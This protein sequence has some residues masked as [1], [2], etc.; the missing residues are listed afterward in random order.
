M[1]ILL[2]FD[3][4]S[5]TSDGDYFSFKDA[6]ADEIESKMPRD[7]SRVAIVQ[8]GTKS[9][10][11]I[12]LDSQMSVEEIAAHV[13]ALERPSGARWTRAAFQDTWTRVTIISYDSSIFVFHFS[14]M[15]LGLV[16]V[17]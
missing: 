5:T 8:Y 1:D 4:D 10:V 2:I 13:R 9:V 17:D 16:A 14:Y 12:G 15:D 3:I 6:I 7:G 11:E